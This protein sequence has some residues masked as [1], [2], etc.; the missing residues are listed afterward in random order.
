MAGLLN[1]QDIWKRC[2][3][4][5]AARARP[6]GRRSC[7]GMRERKKRADWTPIWAC[8]RSGWTS[9]WTGSVLCDLHGIEASIHS[10]YRLL[11]SSAWPARRARSP[12]ASASSPW[13]SSSR[14][15]WP[16]RAVL[17]PSPPSLAKLL[18]SW[19]LRVGWFAASTEEGTCSE[20]PRASTSSSRPF[21][22]ERSSSSSSSSTPPS[23][24]ISSFG[25]PAQRHPPPHREALA[26][27]TRSFSSAPLEIS[28]KNSKDQAEYL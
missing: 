8:A 28:R 20:S 19:E 24:L 12:S 1:K 6:A 22:P 18:I 13:A 10:I 15:L 26:I 21:C 11:P 27:E 4:R 16:L 9:W 17:L 25:R 2:P 5:L 23:S 3:W 14:P 7:L